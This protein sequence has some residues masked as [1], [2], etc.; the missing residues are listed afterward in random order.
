MDELNF[1]TIAKAWKRMVNN[2]EKVSAMQTLSPTLTS[3]NA[4][5]L[6]NIVEQDGYFHIRFSGFENASSETIGIPIIKRMILNWMKQIAEEVKVMDSTNT[7]LN[8]LV[9]VRSK[10]TEAAI[11]IYSRNPKTNKITRKYKCLGGAKNGRKVSDPNQC[12]QYPSVEKRMKMAISK[13][14]TKGKTAKAKSKTRLTNIVSRKV[15]KA[16]Q[17]L[18]KAR[19]M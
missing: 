7:D 19:G 16:N 11:S 2:P 15:R 14:A 6:K 12:L 8:L 18:K 4:I 10:F 3:P 17:R 1:Q 9:S 5:R 13:R